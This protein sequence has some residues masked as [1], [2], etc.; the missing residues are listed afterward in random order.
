MNPGWSWTRR[1]LNGVRCKIA[2]GHQRSSSSLESISYGV[3]RP[4]L[5]GTLGHMLD[6]S[7]SQTMLSDSAHFDVITRNIDQD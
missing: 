5:G 2:R 7:A 6:V 1:G 4:G 3:R